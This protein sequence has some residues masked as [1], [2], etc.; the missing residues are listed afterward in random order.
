MGN[1]LP[2]RTDMPVRMLGV[3]GAAVGV[4]LL[5]LIIHTGDPSSS[6]WWLAAIPFAIWIVGPAIVPYLLARRR[7]SSNISIAM[8]A[9]LVISTALSGNA[10]Y[11][12]LFVSESST[13]ALV[14]LFVPLY[15]WT[16]F[17]VVAGVILAA[18][19]LSKR[20]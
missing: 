5:T 2:V 10:Y 3:M 18:T 11:Q 14:F 13:A 20:R 17:L 9:F 6:S 15:Q 16:A 19:A 8:L 4:G 7:H 12:A 1:D